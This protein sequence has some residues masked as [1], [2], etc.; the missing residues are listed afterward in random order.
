MPYA[1]RPDI[2][3]DDAMRTNTLHIYAIGDVTAGMRLAHVASA[4][5]VIA[6]KTIAGKKPEALNYDDIPRC[7]YTHPEV[8]SVGLTERQ[9]L[10][11]G[12]AVV[13]ARCPFVANGKAMDDNGGFVKIVAEK[14]SK[15]LLGVHLLGCHV[16][17]LV[18]GVSGMIHQ[19]SDAL[20]MG[21]A[22]YPHPTMSEAIMAAA[23]R[24]CGHTIH[25]Q[26]KIEWSRCLTVR[27]SSIARQ[28]ED[29]R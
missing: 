1:V 13:K 9:A 5:A 27:C 26:R 7:T 11:R 14:K 12:Y 29:T 8:A 22:V 16:T 2:E 10:E 4:Q 18:A 21:A 3:V 28:R 17:E 25:I 20:Q 6:A 15:K 23:H 19:N 24:L